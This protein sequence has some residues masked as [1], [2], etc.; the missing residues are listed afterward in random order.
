MNI[1]DDGA[2]ALADGLTGNT[3]LKNLILS[4]RL[5]GITSVGWS[6]FSHVLLDRSIINNTYLSNHA[7]EH[8]GYVTQ[9]P[10][11]KSF[12]PKEIA[13]VIFMMR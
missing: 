5:A 4:P 11:E 9:E 6:A 12:V 2:V 3:S 8:I 10:V 13:F 1:G 7:L